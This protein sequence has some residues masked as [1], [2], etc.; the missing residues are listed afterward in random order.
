MGFVLTFNQDTII[1][2]T[3][4]GLLDPMKWK[5]KQQKHILTD[6]DIIN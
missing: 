2:V 5:K 3:L 6:L 1:L 4:A